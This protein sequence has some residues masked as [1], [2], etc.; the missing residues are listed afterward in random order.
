MSVEGL[1]AD[2]AAQGGLD[3]EGEFDVDIRG[4]MNKMAVFQSS[5]PAFFMLKVLQ[6]AAAAGARKVS[7]SLGAR[8][9][10]VH[11]EKSVSGLDPVA[12]GTG[13]TRAAR[14][15]G[16]ALQ[17]AAGSAPRALVCRSG[18]TE[19]KWESDWTEQPSDVEGTFISWDYPRSGLRSL[20]DGVKTRFHL[21][22]TLKR[23]AGL[24]PGQILIDG[25][26][27]S[28]FY[29]G[30]LS[31][32]EHQK[33]TQV[34]RKDYLLFRRYV[35]S[36]LNHGGMGGV[37]D[38]CCRYCGTKESVVLVGEPLQNHWVSDFSTDS[39]DQ[40]AVDAAIADSSVSGIP[41]TFKGL[42]LTTEPEPDHW[43]TQW[44]TPIPYKQIVMR[45]RA[46]LLL[47]AGMDSSGV[48]YPVIDG[49]LGEPLPA[50]LGIPGAVAVV[51]WELPTDLSQFRLVQGPA[52]DKVI[53][54]VRGHFFE[55]ASSLLEPRYGLH[56]KYRKRVLAS[57][58]S[59][60]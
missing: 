30:D 38:Q 4:A 34:K 11:F 28:E 59:P 19:W 23:R 9:L 18:Q 46:Q 31:P 42:H 17:A 13:P 7:I 10:R 39:G 48:V 52:L 16:L 2:L 44:W 26:P 1:L 49:I 53:E 50:D 54:F 15:L 41:L 29:L 47:R 40:W 56:E 3:S 24:F 57:L 25:F 37:V 51:G 32:I 21:T 22:K 27:L 55:M 5:D 58:N 8:K 12:F 35:L 14:H 36:P 60:G 45:C 33:L 43:Y 6:A 20:I